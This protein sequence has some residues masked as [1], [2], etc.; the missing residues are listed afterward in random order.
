M[1][2]VSHWSVPHHQPLLFYEGPILAQHHYLS[3]HSPNWKYYCL[4]IRGHL[5]DCTSVQA[6]DLFLILPSVWVEGE[7]G[8]EGKA[9]E[10]KE[11]SWT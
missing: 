1:Y 8:E 6:C 5:P 3:V 11:R 7:G 9:N 10:G 2:H 4:L